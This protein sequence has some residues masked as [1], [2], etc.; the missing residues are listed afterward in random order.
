MIRSLRR[1]ITAADNIDSI[2]TAAENI[3]AI[4]DAPDQAMA[5]AQSATMAEQA[6]NNTLSYK[7]EAITAA[8]QAATSNTSSAN[9][10]SQAQS[11]AI[12]EIS[13]RPEGSA[14]YWA[15]LAEQKVGL[16]TIRTNCITSVQNNINLEINNGVL[17]LKAGSKVYI[18]NGS[19]T[20]M[21]AVVKLVALVIF[22]II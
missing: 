20:F 14:K 7:N 17:K 21:S 2:V 8:Q 6:E 10:A 15:E 16:N 1:V 5:A 11:W 4:V 13:T 19:G 9:Y 12:G 18:P 3:E 22:F